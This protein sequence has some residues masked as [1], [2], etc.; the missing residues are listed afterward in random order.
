MGEG[1]SRESAASAQP[2]ALSGRR[3][4]PP[5]VFIGHSGYNLCMCVCMCK[6]K[7]DIVI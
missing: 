4:L 2:W 3:A 5:Q 7:G 1:L 6:I